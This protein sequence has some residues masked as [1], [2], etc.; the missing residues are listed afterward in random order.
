M[1]SLDLFGENL[2]GSLNASR[3]DPLMDQK[4]RFQINVRS[5]FLYECTQAMRLY[6]HGE[7]VR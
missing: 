3:F 5:A 7:G 1:E 2:A 6:S 4:G